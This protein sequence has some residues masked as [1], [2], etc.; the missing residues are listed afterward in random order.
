MVK[1]VMSSDASEPEESDY[2]AKSKEKLIIQQS[3]INS[4]VRTLM[5]LKETT[6]R[7]ISTSS[8]SNINGL[9]NGER[10]SAI[11]D[12]IKLQEVSSC[13]ALV[14]ASEVGW[15]CVYDMTCSCMQ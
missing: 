8:S 1:T 3:L 10:E 11:D 14:V 13:M 12:D 7:L 5:R 4:S 15:A 9:T 2:L 6:S